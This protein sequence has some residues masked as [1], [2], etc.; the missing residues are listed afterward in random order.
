[1]VFK[2]YPRADV[3]T[4]DTIACD[5]FIMHVGSGELRIQ[6]RSAKPRNLEEAINLASE[7]ELIRGLENSTIVPPSEFAIQTVNAPETTASTVSKV[8]GIVEGLQKEIYQLKEVNQGR[9]REQRHQS[10][11]PRNNGPLR[12]LPPRIRRN[13]GDRQC[14][15]CGSWRH[16]IRVCPE[17]TEN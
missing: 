3:D 11:P 17:L 8:L 4:R 1:M 6:L 5:H 10:P 7:I 14:W 9:F 12:L 15:N 2:A 13:Q 16:L